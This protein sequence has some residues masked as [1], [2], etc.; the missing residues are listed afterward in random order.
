MS[1][2]KFTNEHECVMVDGDVAWVG[3]TKYAQEALGD[4]VYVELPEVG[5]Q[6]KKGE[7]FAVVE[8]VKTAAEVYS[9]I[10][11]EVVEAND[12]MPDD[13]EMITKDLADG[14]WIAKIKVSDASQLEALMDETKYKEYVETLD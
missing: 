11:G 14:G 3:I 12:N 9:P 5:K 4:L 7:E 1:E 10:D 2:L 13:L 8:S 6:V